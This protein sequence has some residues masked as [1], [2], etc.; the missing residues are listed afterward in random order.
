MAKKS[1]IWAKVNEKAISDKLFYLYERWQDEKK[2]EDFNDYF[3]V[4]KAM[5]PEA[6]KGTKR[7][8]G[9]VAKADDGECDIYIKVKGKYL[10]LNMAEAM[11]TQD[12]RARIAK[13][14]NDSGI[15]IKTAYTF[16]ELQTIA[17]L[18]HLS[19]HDVM[20]FLR[21]EA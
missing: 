6:V 7:P 21:Y 17:N 2:Y 8:F 20:Y 10:T 12:V 14:V 4:M 9:F 11:P 3:K 1:E 19:I 15:G 5:I 18:V 13:A 16:K